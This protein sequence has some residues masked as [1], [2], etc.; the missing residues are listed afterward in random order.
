MMDSLIDPVTPPSTRRKSLSERYVEIMQ[1]DYNKRKQSHLDNQARRVKISPLM[2]NVQLQYGLTVNPK[3]EPFS[4]SLMKSD[5]E[6]I[7][8]T[9]NKEN[10]QNKENHITDFEKIDGDSTSC[11]STSML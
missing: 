3:L 5:M 6:I 8:I 4:E 9:K 7:N 1:M 11:D 10:Q 2:L